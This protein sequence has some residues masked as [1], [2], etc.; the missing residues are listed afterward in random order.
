VVLHVVLGLPDRSWIRAE[1]AEALETMVA[2]GE[3]INAIVAM[4]SSG[5]KC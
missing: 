4:G 5:P 1:G 3:A 2:R